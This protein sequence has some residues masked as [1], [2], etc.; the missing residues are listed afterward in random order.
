MSAPAQVTQ[1]CQRVGGKVAPRKPGGVIATV[2]PWSPP[3]SDGNW[4]AIEGSATASI[5]VA[6]AR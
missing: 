5:S 6:P 3:N 2:S 1:A 4:L